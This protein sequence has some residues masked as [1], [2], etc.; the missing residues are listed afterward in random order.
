M[1]KSES[2]DFMHFGDGDLESF[3]GD[4]IV[5]GC[6]AL[7]LFGSLKDSL[8]LSFAIFVSDIFEDLPNLIRCS[9]LV[10]VLSKH[11]SVF[12]FFWVD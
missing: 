2:V 5:D 3:Y 10:E 12:V 9:L 7:D 6:A 4:E 11:A 8:V 1:S